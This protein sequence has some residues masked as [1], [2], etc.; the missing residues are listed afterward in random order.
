[1]IKILAVCGNGMGTSTV[2]KMKVSQ[3]LS[4]Q[5][6]SADVSTC[7]LG[8]ASGKV[9]EMNIVLCSKHLGE[10]ISVPENVHLILLKNLLDPN[11]FGPALLEILKKG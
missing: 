7:S 8:E 9:G 1:M 6:I 2:I 4:S 3:F 5:N 11:E 10:Q